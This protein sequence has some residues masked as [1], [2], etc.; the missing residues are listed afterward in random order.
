MHHTTLQPKGFSLLEL[1]LVIM[2]I[3]ILFLASR[4]LFS[5]PYK[6]LIDSEA[7]INTLH[8][9]VNKFFFQSISGKD[10]STGSVT[11]EPSYYQLNITSNSS[12]SST[13]DFNI[14]TWSNNNYITINT[15]AINTGDTSLQY[16]KQDNYIL[17]LSWSDITSLSGVYITIAKWLDTNSS[18]PWIS[19]CTD[20][21]QT[22]CKT[23]TFIDYISCE[24]TP[25]WITNDTC[26]TIFAQRF[27]TRTQTLKSNRCLN[28]TYSTTCTQ[29]SVDPEVFYQ[30]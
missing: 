12:G 30:E 23:T 18:R 10:Q 22:N 5:T 1:V 21:V 20:D 29:R 19:I 9:E 26:K 28:S 4:T 25:S 27:D 16:C 3:S 24:Y 13:I 6:Y 14:A 17:L 11:Y 15:L 2:I 8:G 7:C